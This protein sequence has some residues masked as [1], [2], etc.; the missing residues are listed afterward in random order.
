MFSVTKKKKNLASADE[1]IHLAVSLHQPTTE[2]V[3]ER[4]AVETATR[5]TAIRAAVMTT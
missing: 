1:P 4:V 5:K 2:R 3:T